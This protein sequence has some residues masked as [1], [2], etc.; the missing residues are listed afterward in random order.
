MKNRRSG[1]TRSGTGWRPAQERIWSQLEAQ[2][3]GN[4][5]SAKVAERLAQSVGPGDPHH[6]KPAE[7]V[8]GDEPLGRGNA[9]RRASGN[10]GIH[11]ELGTIVGLRN[12]QRKDFLGGICIACATGTEQVL[13]MTPRKAPRGFDVIASALIAQVCVN[14]AD[15]PSQVPVPPDSS[16]YP[17]SAPVPASAAFSASDELVA[18]TKRSIR[19]R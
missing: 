9:G 6:V 12:F 17:A 18:P 5:S 15:N 10:R 13:P 3:A 1:K 11:Q 4:G 19:I 7:R 2:G 16:Q 14:A 8:Q